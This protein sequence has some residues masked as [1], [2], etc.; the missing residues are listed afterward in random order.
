MQLNASTCVGF[1]AGAFSAPHPSDDAAKLACEI[2][3]STST[4]RCLALVVLT[5]DQGRNTTRRFPPGDGSALRD[6]STACTVRSTGIDA[7]D[8]H[9][10]LI[11]EGRDC[12]GGT[13]YSLIEEIYVLRDGQPVLVK[14][15]SADF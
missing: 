4:D 6:P 1:D 15:S 11:G 10:A 2:Q 8:K 9:F 13:A 14:R 5:R 7:S 12:F 3:P